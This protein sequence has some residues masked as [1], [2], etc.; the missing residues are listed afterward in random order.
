[1]SF[2]QQRVLRSPTGAELKL[3]VKRAEGRPRA[4]VQIN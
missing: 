3:Y 2:S 1:M 4:V